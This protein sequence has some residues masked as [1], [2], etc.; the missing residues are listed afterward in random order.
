[1]TRDALQALPPKF[2]MRE[3]ATME[4]HDPAGPVPVPDPAPAATGGTGLETTE[5]FP[6]DVVDLPL[7]ELHVLH[8]KL[9]RQLDHE[10]LTNPAGPHPLTQDRHQEVVAELDTRATTEPA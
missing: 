8:S 3:T 4:T 7:T 9:C 5:D 1:M 10:T 6:T 2:H